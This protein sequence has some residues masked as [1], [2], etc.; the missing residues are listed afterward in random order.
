MNVSGVYRMSCISAFY[1][2]ASNYTLDIA[3][4]FY[5]NI[6]AVA[7]DKQTQSDYG[8]CM[9]AN[10]FHFGLMTH[11]NNVEQ[12]MCRKVFRLKNIYC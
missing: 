6:S 4:D 11:V 12:N 9:K 1:Y 2:G 5:R 7:P 10:A 8:I 3:S